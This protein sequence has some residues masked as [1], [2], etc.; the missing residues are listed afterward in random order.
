V[1]AEIHVGPPG[2]WPG[3]DKIVPKVTLSATNALP[4]KRAGQRG[5]VDSSHFIHETIPRIE[6]GVHVSLIVGKKV[7]RKAG[8]EEQPI[9]QR[10]FRILHG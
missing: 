9:S 6:R 2:E 4:A 3:A 1:A 8:L 10:D 5:T 7:L